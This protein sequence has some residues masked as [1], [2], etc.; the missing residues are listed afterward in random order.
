MHDTL[1]G[2]QAP[3]QASE[4]ENMGNVLA[5][6]ESSACGRNT[7]C[8][9]CCKSAGN[10]I[11]S[12]KSQASNVMPLPSRTRR[13]R[14]LMIRAASFKAVPTAWTILREA[15]ARNSLCRQKK[16]LLPQA[17][18]FVLTRNSCTVLMPARLSVAVGAAFSRSAR[19]AQAGS[20]M[21]RN[22]PLNLSPDGLS[23]GTVA[24][25]RRALSLLPA[26]PP[27]S[28][29]QLRQVAGALQ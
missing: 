29:L 5:G 23:K 6:H 14:S 8:L 19:H 27:L 3:T 2:R 11:D 1:R 10:L 9:K 13:L 18:L 7:A 15:R 26:S 20:R 4:E 24:S 17:P 28:A 25:S 21:K 16:L 12:G 22:K